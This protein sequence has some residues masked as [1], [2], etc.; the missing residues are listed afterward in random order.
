MARR[1]QL[2]LDQ[3]NH[4]RHILAT[5]SEEFSTRRE[6]DSVNIAIEETKVLETCRFLLR[7][8]VENEKLELCLRSQNKKCRCRN[9][10]F[11]SK[12]FHTR[13]ESDSANIFLE[14]NSSTKLRHLLGSCCLTATSKQDLLQKEGEAE[15]GTAMLQFSN[16]AWSLV[17]TRYSCNFARTNINFFTLG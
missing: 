1:R 12:E 11:H 9:L 13:R 3:E 8:I 10:A 15:L 4:R 2:N 14:N 7:G 16:V 6:S 17:H 5:F